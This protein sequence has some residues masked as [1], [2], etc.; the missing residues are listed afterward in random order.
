MQARMIGK[1]SVPG[2]LFTDDLAGGQFPV[3]LL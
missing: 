2:V 3:N 1:I